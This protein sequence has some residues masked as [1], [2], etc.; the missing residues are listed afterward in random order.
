MVRITTTTAV[1]LT[2]V[3][4][5][6]HKLV[7][8]E[9][10]PVSH[11]QVHGSNMGRAFALR[12][13]AHVQD[14]AAMV[15]QV[16]AA[17][18]APNG[19]SRSFFVTSPAGTHVALY[20]SGDRSFAAKRI[21]WHLS[22][23]A[24]A[25]LREL[26]PCHDFEVAK[27]ANAVCIG[28]QELVRATFDHAHA[29]STRSGTE[30]PSLTQDWQWKRP[31]RCTT[32]RWRRARGLTTGDEAYPD[33]ERPARGRRWPIG[34][35]GRR[36]GRCH[37]RRASHTTAP[38]TNAPRRQPRRHTTTHNAPR[39]EAARRGPQRSDR[40]GKWRPGQD[41]APSETNGT[42]GHRRQGHE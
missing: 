14:H 25:A 18:K 5:E 37:T 19:Q 35:R 24:A 21:G 29:R 40:D 1:P 6:V 12:F 32:M 2:A 38:T 15:T 8:V 3:T 27:G 36:G 28:C 42:A 13:T 22:R 11:K 9:G 30:R 26:R 23:A 31:L 7:Q 20:I 34:R 16:L 17:K 41:G 39:H 10:V 33:M 4:E